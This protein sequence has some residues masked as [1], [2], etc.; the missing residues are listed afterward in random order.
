MLIGY[1]LTQLASET[2]NLNMV[3]TS[4]TDKKLE[5]YDVFSATGYLLFN[6]SHWMFAFRY[7]TMARYTP[8]KVTQQEVPREMIRCD[9]ITNWVFLSLNSVPPVLNGVGYIGYH[10]ANLN[11]KED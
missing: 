2:V 1:N 7:Y 10:I 11:G 6:V 4:F 9:K 5:I 8:Y 3:N